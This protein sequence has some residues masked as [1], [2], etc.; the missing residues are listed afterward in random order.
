MCYLRDEVVWDSN[1]I[2]S[3]RVEKCLEIPLDEWLSL[4]DI[5]DNEAFI[6][7]HIYAPRS[8]LYF[9]KILTS[10]QRV[11]IIRYLLGGGVSIRV[12]VVPNYSYYV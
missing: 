10:K 9:E 5:W 12:K 1:N 3:A 8:F 6:D 7:A 11:S 2:N 4:D